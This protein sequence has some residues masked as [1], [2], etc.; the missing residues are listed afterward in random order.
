MT[1]RSTISFDYANLKDIFERKYIQKDNVKQS[2]LFFQDKLESEQR[3]LSQ[4]YVWFCLKHND[5]LDDRRFAQTFRV[6]TFF[7]LAHGTKRMRLY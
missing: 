3:A 2:Q 1:E 6:N 7:F 5:V 4:F